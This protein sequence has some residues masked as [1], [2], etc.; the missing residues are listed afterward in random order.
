MVRIGILFHGGPRHDQTAHLPVA[1]N[2]PMVIVPADPASGQLID[3]AS[4]RYEPTGRTERRD[5]EVC[6]VF[7]YKAPEAA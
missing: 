5:G 2:A 3:S 4:E 7:T 1:P 6:W